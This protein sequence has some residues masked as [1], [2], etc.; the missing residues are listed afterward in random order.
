MVDA[1]SLKFGLKFV[2]MS[3][4]PQF[5]NALHAKSLVDSDLNSTNSKIVDATVKNIQTHYFIIKFVLFI[6][7]EAL[8]VKTVNNTVCIATTVISI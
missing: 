5:E 6:Q 4:A 3:F 7:F 8:A 1:R 2:I